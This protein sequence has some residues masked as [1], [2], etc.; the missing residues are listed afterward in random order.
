MR[1]IINIIT[2]HCKCQ[3]TVSFRTEGVGF[4]SRLDQKMK[5]STGKFPSLIQVS[6]AKNY[7]QHLQ[8]P[9]MRGTLK[10]VITTKNAAVNT[11]A[12][13]LWSEVTDTQMPSIPSY[14]NY[15]N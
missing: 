2:G 3:V 14:I 10:L 13:L 12:A 7:N 4:D 6:A 15:N 11:T 8:H 1:H 5:L 9:N